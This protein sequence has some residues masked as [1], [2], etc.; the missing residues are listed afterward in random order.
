MSILSQGRL[1][2]GMAEYGIQREDQTA[3]QGR[4]LDKLSHQLPAVWEPSARLGLGFRL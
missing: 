2:I 1:K 4:D 3:N